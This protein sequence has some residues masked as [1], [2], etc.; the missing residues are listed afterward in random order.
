MILASLISAGLMNVSQAIAILTGFSVGNCVLLFIVSMNLSVGIMFLLGICGMAIFLTK[1]EKRLAY[2]QVGLGLGLIF[3]G[4]IMMSAGV[5]PL[6]HEVWFAGAME[7]T[8][9]YSLLSIMVGVGLGFV[10]QS[11]TVVALVAI[12]L[13]REDILTGPQCFLLL[14][15][16]AL[17]STGFKVLLGQA[18]RGASRQL[19]RFVNLFNVFGA[20]VFILLYYIEVGLHVPLVMNL[21]QS[22]HLDLVQQAA[23]VFLLFNLTSAF[24]FSWPS[25]SR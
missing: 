2:Y 24:F 12:G 19:V 22:F 6:Q 3:F 14:Y 1:D 7:L 23:W 11:S 17:G 8:R 5:K 10:V 25:I 16:A 4:N 15:G 20:A 18:F 9:Q 13:A 21:L